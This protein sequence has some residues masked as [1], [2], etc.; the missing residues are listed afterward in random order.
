MG[1]IV[2][3]ALGCPEKFMDFNIV[4]DPELDDEYYFRSLKKEKLRRVIVN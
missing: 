3:D 4:I 1:Q 2:Y